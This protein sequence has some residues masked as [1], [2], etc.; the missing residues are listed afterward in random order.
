MGM[1]KL[2]EAAG[3]RMLVEDEP[4]HQVFQQSPGGEARCHQMEALDSGEVRENQNG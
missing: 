4:V 1:M 3:P 2:M